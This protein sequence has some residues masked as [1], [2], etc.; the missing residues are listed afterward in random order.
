MISGQSNALNQMPEPIAD[1]QHHREVVYY[2]CTFA[3]LSYRF[4]IVLR[5]SRKRSTAAQF[6]R[7]VGI[8]LADEDAF[9]LRDYF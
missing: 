1:P 3:T 6:V 4:V 2:C 9:A 8:S 7:C 5:S